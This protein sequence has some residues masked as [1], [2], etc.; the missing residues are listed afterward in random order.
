MILSVQTEGFSADA[1]I[2]A[3]GLKR[4]A[5]L[6][7]WKSWEFADEREMIF[8]FMKYFLKTD[9]KIVIGF[10]NLKLD[11]P[12]LLLRSAGLPSF[13]EFFKKMNYANAEDLF[14]I[15]TFINRGVIK[16][17]DYYCKKEGIACDFSDR[18]IISAYNSKD[19]AR[20]QELFKKKLEAMDAL[21]LKM[22]EKVTKG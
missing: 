16:G 7:I 19:Y 15:L 22:W 1:K 17:L 18:E 8:D 5:F 20:F 11:I 14:V 13:G 21:F 12:L 2:L 3:I 4:Q 9:D 6:R 10:N